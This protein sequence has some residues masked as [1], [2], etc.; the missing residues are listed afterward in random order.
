VIGKTNKVLNE[1]SI[2]DTINLQWYQGPFLDA[3]ED[4]YGHVMAILEDG[5]ILLI[6]GSR[7]NGTNLDMYSVT[8]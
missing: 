2:L 6:G 3:P 4:R 8:I 7:S 5:N 1:L